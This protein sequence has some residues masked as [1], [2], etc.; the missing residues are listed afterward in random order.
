LKRIATIFLGVLL[1]CGQDVFCQIAVK[2]LKYK[3][4]YADSINVG[5][6]GGE[7]NEK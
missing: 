4:R 5:Y 2:V 7:K 1:V 6:L 3:I